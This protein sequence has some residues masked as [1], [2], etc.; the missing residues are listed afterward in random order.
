MTPRELLSPQIRA[1]LF[2]PPTDAPEIVRHYTFPAED[3]ELIQKRRR[4]HN[5]LGFAVHLAYLR[6]PGRVLAPSEMPP[7]AM[8]GYIADQLNVSGAS[9]SDYANREV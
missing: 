2:D 4:P 1:A 6:H 9:F 7:P 3:M 5:R 8:L